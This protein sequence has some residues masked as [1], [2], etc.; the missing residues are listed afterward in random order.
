MFETSRKASLKDT[1]IIGSSR[2]KDHETSG[3]YAYIESVLIAEILGI[4]AQAE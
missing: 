4:N 1:S 3:T 2:A